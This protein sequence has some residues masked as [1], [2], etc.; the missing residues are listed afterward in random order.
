MG[1]KRNTPRGGASFKKKARKRD[2]P[3]EK[4]LEKKNAH[5]D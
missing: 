3:K 2:N 4:N 5:P 1:S